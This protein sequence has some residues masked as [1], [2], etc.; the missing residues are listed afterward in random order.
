M[1]TKGWLIAACTALLALDVVAALQHSLN[2]EDALSM[3]AAHSAP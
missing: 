3:K 1:K 2:L